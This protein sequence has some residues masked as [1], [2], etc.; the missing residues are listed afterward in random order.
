[1]FGSSRILFLVIMNH[2]L[3]P[4]EDSCVS[5]ASSEDSAMPSLVSSAESLDWYAPAPAPAL[6]QNRWNRTKR[7]NE[8]KAPGFY[9]TDLQAMLPPPQ[10]SGQPSASSHQPY[11]SAPSSTGPFDK[12]SNQVCHGRTTFRPCKRKGC[13]HRRRCSSPRRH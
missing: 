13:P 8:N 7:L 1:M 5:P 9:D 10:A 11:S 12:V 3:V 6:R 4:M 2:S